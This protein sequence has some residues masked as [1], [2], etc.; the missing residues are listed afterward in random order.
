MLDSELAG[1]LVDF[2]SSPS[3]T[4]ALAVTAGVAFWADAS[5][6]NAMAKAAAATVAIKYFTRLLP[7]PLSNRTSR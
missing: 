3:D 1:V 6:M 4:S 5:A 2:F 7:G